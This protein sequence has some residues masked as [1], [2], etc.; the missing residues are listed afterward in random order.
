MFRQSCSRARAHDLPW[1]VS[2]CILGGRTQARRTRFIRPSLGYER[3]ATLSMAP[4]D[5]PRLILVGSPLLSLSPPPPTSPL[6]LGVRGLVE[7]L[8]FALSWGLPST[9]CKPLSR[10]SN[11]E[12][13]ASSAVRPGPE[14]Y[15]EIRAWEENARWEVQDYGFPSPE[16]L[17]ESDTAGHTSASY[18]SHPAVF[19]PPFPEE[20]L[21]RP[22]APVACPAH[23]TSPSVSV[24]ESSQNL[25]PLWSVPKNPRLLP[26]LGSFNEP[27]WDNLHPSSG[28][29]SPRSHL[30]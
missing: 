21:A 2:A 24:F 12:T 13:Q 28:I 17:Y 26:G 1:G 5:S 6:F 29:T 14:W 16:A 23:S 9:L 25:P 22:T 15:A 18:D 11:T 27:C 20:R 4:S 10:G 8:P 7:H 19:S 3:V 30:L